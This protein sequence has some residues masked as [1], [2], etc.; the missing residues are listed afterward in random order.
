MRCA[1]TIVVAF[2]PAWAGGCTATALAAQGALAPEAEIETAPVD[3]DGHIFFHMRTPAP[4][5]LQTALA[6]FAVTYALNVICAE[7]SRMLEVYA[8]LHRQILDVFNEVRR[9]NHD[10]GVYGGPARTQGRSRPISGT[11]P[12]A[13]GTDRRN[14]GAIASGVR[15]VPSEANR[16]RGACEP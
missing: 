11:R 1:V 10:T 15:P 2:L 16:R 8:D 13:D 12:P 7:A 3:L 9:A 6:N 5:V 4:F 14:T